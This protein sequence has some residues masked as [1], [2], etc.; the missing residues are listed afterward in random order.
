MAT[1]FHYFAI[2][3]VQNVNTSLFETLSCHGITTTYQAK[4]RHKKQKSV[5]VVPKSSTWFYVEDLGTLMY[6]K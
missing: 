5:H 1:L 2:L 6:K 3:V 4:W